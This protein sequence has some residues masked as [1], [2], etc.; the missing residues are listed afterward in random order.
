MR[1]VSTFSTAI[2]FNAVIFQV[3]SAQLFAGALIGSLAAA[4]L[5]LAW[6]RFGHRLNL[7]LFLQVSAVFLMVFVVQLLFYGF[8]E[9]TEAN[10]FPN[11][12]ALHWA[13]EPYGPDGKYGKLLSYLLVILPIGWLMIAG[14]RGR[15]ALPAGAGAAGTVVTG[16]A[17]R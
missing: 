6:V 2:L 14:L 5:A 16:P 4:L 1:R 11:S 9:L 10:L 7:G 15:R 3:K 17:D 12:E 13:S 8:H